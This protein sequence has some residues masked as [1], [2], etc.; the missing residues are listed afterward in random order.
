MKTKFETIKDVITQTKEK[1]QYEGFN[2]IGIFG[3][4]ARGTQNRY[5]DVDIAYTIDFNTFNDKYKGGFS[6]LLHIE[7]IK[8]ELQKSLGLK[9]DLISL[10]ASNANIKQNIK[11]DILYV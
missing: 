2:I 7:E 11:E 3:S 6:K 4:Y 9:V 8:N 5:S 10:D 1:Y